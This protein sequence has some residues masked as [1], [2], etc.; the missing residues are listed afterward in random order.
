MRRINLPL[1]RESD[2]SEK[3]RMEKRKK[4]KKREENG[5]KRNFKVAVKLGYEIK[6]GPER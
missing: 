5:G 6:T 1:E 3:K 4:K 2:A